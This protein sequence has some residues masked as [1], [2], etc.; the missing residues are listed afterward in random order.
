[1]SVIPTAASTTNSTASARSTAISA[2]ARDAL[3]EPARVGVPAA[4]VDDRE[5]AAV[6]VGVVGHPVAG[7]PGT[8]STTAS[9]RPMIRLT[10]VD[11]P[12]LGRPTTARTGTGPCASVS[13]SLVVSSGSCG[14]LVGSVIGVSCRRGEPGRVGR[15]WQRRRPDGRSTRARG[16]GG[17]ARSARWN[18]GTAPACPCS[19]GLLAP[20]ARARRPAR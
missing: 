12:T 2:C 10:S 3:G 6:P 1:M 13:G 9:R 7:D 11:L 20:P 18:A 8:S 15:R 17:P 4:G 19:R 5:R 16:P 14:D